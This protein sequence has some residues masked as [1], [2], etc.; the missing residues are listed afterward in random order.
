M[1]MSTSLELQPVI[2]KKK[3]V[4]KESNGPTRPEKKGSQK[5]KK[6]WPLVHAVLFEVLSV[7][8]GVVV[9]DHVLI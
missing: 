7:C 4:K 9:V 2:L 6:P 8:C 5:E 1:V 3:G